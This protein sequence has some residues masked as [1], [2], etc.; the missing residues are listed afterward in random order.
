M[1]IESHDR[2]DHLAE[3]DP[4]TGRVQEF[5]RATSSPGISV[6]TMG[7]YARLSGTIAVLYRLDKSLWLRIGDE[8]R[9][10]DRKGIEVRWAHVRGRSTLELLDTGELVASVRYRPGPGGGPGD[11]TPFAESEDWDFGLFVQ[12]VL[13]D[14]SRRARIY[15]GAAQL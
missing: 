13:G 3:F 5:G 1:R 15:G 14:E 7:H 4:T 12:N 2:F 8:A 11:P 9:A 6:Q 10:L